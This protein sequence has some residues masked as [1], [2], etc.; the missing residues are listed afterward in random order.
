MH[1]CGCVS[2]GMCVDVCVVLCECVCGCVYVFVYIHVCGCVSVGMYID[3]GVS[4]P[5][6]CMRTY[7]PMDIQYMSSSVQWNQYFSLTLLYCT[8]VHTVAVVQNA[9]LQ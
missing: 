9:Y 7:V 6:F 4:V 2:V 3:V 5:I 8:Y 1:V